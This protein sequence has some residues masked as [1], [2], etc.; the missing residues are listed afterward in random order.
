MGKEMDLNQIATFKQLSMIFKAL[1]Q[2]NERLGHFQNGQPVDGGAS[3]PGASEKYFGNLV[4]QL[5][6]T[7]SS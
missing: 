5:D 3:S 7:S 2:I 6:R 1:R 4:S